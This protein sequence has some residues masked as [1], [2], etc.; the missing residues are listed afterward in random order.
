MAFQTDIFTI[1][2]RASIMLLREARDTNEL[3]LGTRQSFFNVCFIIQER[4]L[5]SLRDQNIVVVGGCEPCLCLDS[6]LGQAVRPGAVGPAASVTR[7]LYH[8]PL[9]LSLSLSCLHTTITSNHRDSASSTS[10]QWL[11]W[12]HR[13]RTQI[14]QGSHKLLLSHLNNEMIN[15]NFFE[16][17]WVLMSGSWAWG[18]GM[19]V[20]GDCW[21]LFSVS[22]VVFSGPDIRHISHQIK[23]FRE[24]PNG[25]P[26]CLVRIIKCP[27]INFLTSLSFI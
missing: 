4:R 7:S 26:M 16:I 24:A 21:K 1:N 22:V 14:H 5:Q 27:V 8:R 23:I 3:M 11:Q 2:V 15:D 10:D 25:D 17:C 9:S 20:A 19:W 6:S 13:T 18:W 12:G